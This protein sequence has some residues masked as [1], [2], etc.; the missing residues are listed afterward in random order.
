MENWEES[1]GGRE[2]GLRKRTRE[3]KRGEERERVPSDEQHGRERQVGR[4]GKRRRTEKEITTEVQRRG[5]EEEG[6]EKRRNETEN[7]KR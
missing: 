1:E 3:R 2:E 5:R 6:K 4:N 7:K